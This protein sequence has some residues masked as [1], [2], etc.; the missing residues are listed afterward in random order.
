M[1][2][3]AWICG[4]LLLCA[5]TG[6]RSLP[7]PTTEQALTDTPTLN[8]NP[9]VLTAAPTPA[10]MEME[11]EAP[12]ETERPTPIP[13]PTPTP[14][15]TPTATPT[16]TPIPI[17]FTASRE[18][19]LPSPGTQMQQGRTFRF[20]GTVLSQ[21]PLVR[22][23][24]I[25]LQ[26]DGAEV[27]RADR[28][29]RENQAI[30]SVQLVDPAFSK[31]SDALAEAIAFE[32]LSEGNYTLRLEAEDNSGTVLT[33]AETAFAI[34]N[35]EWHTL[36]PNQFR[37]TYS[38]ALAF[39]GS[40]EKFLFRYKLQNESSHITVDPDWRAQYDGTA[41]GIG[42]RQWQC[43]V[44]AIPYFEQA[45]K[46]ID[47]TFIRI[48]GKLSGKAFDTGAVRLSDL[49]TYSGTI[50]RRFDA[51]NTFINHHSFGTAIDFNAE[52]PSQTERLENRDR[53]F[54]EVTQNLT[55]NG[56]IE[57]D[58]QLCYDF[59]YN[60]RAKVGLCGVPEPVMNY[61]LYELG[62]FRAGFGWGFYYPHTCDAAHYSLTELS[63]SLFTE[64]DYAMRKVAMYIEDG[65]RPAESPDPNETPTPAPEAE[66]AAAEP[67]AEPEQT[68]NTAVPNE[69]DPIPEST[70]PA[71]TP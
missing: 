67:G 41:V 4:M 37:L 32:T 12:V 62:F 57:L 18:L 8:P 29:F 28:K 9:V 54:Q 2:R 36:Q 35:S 39:F 66:Q 14:S 44:D 31:K 13:T 61:L 24:A 26:E 43:H 25:V 6:C 68:E 23:S 34:T 45:A 65:A 20:D 1:K 47:G 63:P 51:D 50:V 71:E 10:S 48:S 55:Y 7:V 59:T 30:A 3:I 42:G 22:L 21:N 15:P 70:E 19:P 56:V 17:T 49:A 46:L 33:L 64:G 53:I 38:T 40:P 5:L 11:I 27:L 58:G 52:Y 69:A 16:P 60:G